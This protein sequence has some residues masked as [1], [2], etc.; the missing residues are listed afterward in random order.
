MAIR[1]LGRFVWNVAGASRS[2]GGPAVLGPERRSGAGRCS[3]H[4]RSSSPF[5][6]RGA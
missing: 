5:G 3:P 6:R 4:P 2:F 1:L